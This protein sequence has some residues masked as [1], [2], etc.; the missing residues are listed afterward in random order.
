[1]KE[2]K[3]DHFSAEAYQLRRIADELTNIY[4]VLKSVVNYCFVIFISLPA[5]Y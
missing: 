5:D 2:K 3:N 1:M 4:A